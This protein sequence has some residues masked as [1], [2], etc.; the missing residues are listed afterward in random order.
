MTVSIHCAPLLAAILLLIPAVLAQSVPTTGTGQAMLD[1]PLVGDVA[2]PPLGGQLTSGVDMAFAVA[3]DKY[4]NTVNTGAVTLGFTIATAL[5]VG[6]QVTFTVPKGYFTNVDSTKVNTFTGTSATCKCVGSAGTTTDAMTCTVAGAGLAV[7]ATTLSMSVGALTTGAPTAA[8]TY[9]VQTTT[10]RQLANAPATQQIGGVISAPGD[11]V[12][13]SVD[14]IPSKVNTVVITSGFTV[15]TPVPIG[16]RITLTFPKAYLSAVSSTVVTFAGKTTATCVL[17][18][19]TGTGTKD[20]VVCTT[21]VEILAAAAQ[22]L[23]SPLAPSHLGCCPRA[24]ARTLCHPQPTGKAVQRHAL[25][26]VP[27]SLTELH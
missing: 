9:N 5:P 18:A 1:Q 23:L 6:G 15:A 24:L 27:P 3:A 4:P 7:G 20:T 26:L 11:L 17:N 16:G 14:A 2:L 12:V 8:S 19:A 10:D 25:L 13:N 22:I 21:A